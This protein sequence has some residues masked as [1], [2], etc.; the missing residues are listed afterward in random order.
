MFSVCLQKQLRLF[1]RLSVMMGLSWIVG[2]LAG[3]LDFRPLYYVFIMLYTLQGVF[4]FAAFTVTRAARLWLRQMVSRCSGALFCK[5]CRRGRTHARSS[6]SGELGQS[7][8]SARRRDRSRRS[9]WRGSG[10]TRSTK[11]TQM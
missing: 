10:A 6:E 9:A 5:R 2:L 4:V 7:A 8:E 3:L 11:T 1:S